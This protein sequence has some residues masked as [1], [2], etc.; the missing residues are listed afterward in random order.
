MA[1]LHSGETHPALGFGD[2]PHGLQ[3]QRQRGL[4]RPIKKL[5]SLSTS[6]PQAF[7]SVLLS[8]FSLCQP[9]P[10][11]MAHEATRDGLT[12]T[13]RVTGAFPQGRAMGSRETKIYLLE[14]GRKQPETETAQFHTYTT[15]VCSPAMLLPSCTRT[16]SSLLR[17]LCLGDIYSYT[18][19]STGQGI[20]H[21]KY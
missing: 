18:V 13:L 7:S 9:R 1:P 14:P 5:F 6:L 17:P 20:Q 16:V 15:P 12:C 21:N 2:K 3:Y 19:S 11:F 10:L 4:G 8:T